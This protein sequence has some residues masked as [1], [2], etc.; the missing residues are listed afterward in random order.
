MNYTQSPNRKEARRILSEITGR[1]ATF[2][3]RKVDKPLIL[4]GAGNLGKMAKNYFEEL[5][6]SFLMVIDAKPDL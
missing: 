4:Y 5:N 1:S 2:T 3:P 6:I